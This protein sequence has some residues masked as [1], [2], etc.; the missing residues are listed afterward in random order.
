M[1]PGRVGVPYSVQFVP[2]G[3]TPPYAVQLLPDDLVSDLPPGLTLSSSG[4]LSGIPTHAGS[5]TL[6]LVVIDDA[7]GFGARLVHLTIDNA[8]GEAPAVTMTPR[9][10]QV[11]HVNGV[12]TN[13]PVPVGVTATNGTLPFNIHL[14]G[15][16]G[17][18][19]S[20]Q[21]GTTP[22]AL[23]LDLAAGTQGLGTFTGWLALSAPGSVNPPDEIPVTLTV[24]AAPP[25]TFT[26][27]PTS[28]SA[29]AAGGVGSFNV[30]TPV[31][32]RV[33]GDDGRCI[34]LHH[35]RRG[36]HR[37]RHGELLDYCESG[38][39][40]TRRQ[41]FGERAELLNHPVRLCL[42]VR[43]AP[44]VD[45]GHRRRRHAARRRRCLSSLLRLERVE[46]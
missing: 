5:F 45:F 41:H 33:D 16:P 2:A 24:V 40:V 10:I 29:I 7:G 34:R 15:I 46:R 38:H 6:T 13:V 22:G 23:T 20:A 36:R 4:L 37:F 14:A 3:G 43:A 8:A 9:A 42:L 11:L 21:A 31:A 18:S 26:L 19:L 25:C 44:G 1:S 35:F 32:L 30:S 28:A 27:N 17:A 12:S 39:D